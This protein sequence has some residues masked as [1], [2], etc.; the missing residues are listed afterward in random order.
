MNMSFIA[1]LAIV[2]VVAPANYEQGTA[3]SY[4]YDITLGSH[5]SLWYTCTYPR[6]AQS[7][8]YGKAL[9]TD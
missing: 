3:Y 7:G 9:I 1:A 2:V 5:A 4:S 8:M 6:H